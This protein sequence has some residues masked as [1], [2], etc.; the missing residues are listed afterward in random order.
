MT[1]ALRFACPIL[2][3]A[4]FS[5]ALLLLTNSALETDLLLVGVGI[6]VSLL[7]VGAWDSWCIASVAL[8]STLH[9]LLSPLSP[10]IGG[11]VFFAAVFLPR[12]LGG[13]SRVH[14]AGIFLLAA[15]GGGLAVG[16]SN[17]YAQAHLVRF[18]AANLM[19]VVLIGSAL[20][21]AVDESVAR[22]LR[23]LAQRS[24]GRARK[25]LLRA[26]VIRRRYP[27]VLEG[28][29]ESARAR[30]ARAWDEL[31]FVARRQVDEAGVRRS[32]HSSRIDAY[33]VALQSA[34]RAAQTSRQVSTA[35]DD[36]VLV[37]L[38]SE[39][40]Q[41]QASMEAWRDVQD[42][43]PHLPRKAP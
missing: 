27:F 30:I 3:A 34:T 20:L 33:V 35:I 43:G 42:L 14:G 29:S 9:V 7:L 15:L 13:R 10:E 18:W 39:H 38:W 2:C 36:D 22:S 40:E 37:Q 12:A 32:V 31:V 25:S 1:R 26:L 8:G 5:L 24:K 21:P 11:A 41:L 16:L 19:G 17:A 23:R 28:F 6:A 4:G